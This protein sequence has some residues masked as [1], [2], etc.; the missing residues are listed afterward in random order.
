MGP[1][2]LESYTETALGF[3]VPTLLALSCIRLDVSPT[4]LSLRFH[5]GVEGG[6]GSSAHR[7]DQLLD[8]KGVLRCCRGLGL[9]GRRG[10]DGGGSVSE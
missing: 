2:T 6:S 4:G 3:V 7:G 8:L 5:R 10:G 9:S 1:G